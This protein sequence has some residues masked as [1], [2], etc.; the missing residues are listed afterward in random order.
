MARLVVDVVAGARITTILLTTTTWAFPLTTTIFL[1]QMMMTC[2]RRQT[3]T[4]CRR[5]QKT[6]KTLRQHSSLPAVP[7]LRVPRNASTLAL[8]QALVWGQV[9]TLGWVLP[10]G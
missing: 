10:T 5:R 3:T 4:T 7:P 6:T 8:I 1:P 9:I 2:R